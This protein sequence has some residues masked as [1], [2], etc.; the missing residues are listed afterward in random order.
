MY[1]RPRI[2]GWLLLL[3][4]ADDC[5]DVRANI[6]PP[7]RVRKV[8]DS[9]I[10]GNAVMKYTRGKLDTRLILWKPWAEVEHDAE[11]STVQVS[12]GRTYIRQDPDEWVVVFE[13]QV[14]WEAYSPERLNSVLVL[15]LEVDSDCGVIF[16]RLCS[17]NSPPVGLIVKHL[18]YS[19]E[20]TLKL[21]VVE[22]AVHGVTRSLKRHTDKGS[23]VGH[24]Q[25]ALLDGG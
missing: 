17:L 10:G 25:L 21:R 5:M 15:V 7:Q 23:V 2:I 18:L 24:I 1:E 19:F 8:A 16:H 12:H 14:V 4:S 22:A 3:N 9:V 6:F 13:L 11:E 20:A